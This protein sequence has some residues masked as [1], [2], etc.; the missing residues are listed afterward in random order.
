MVGNKTKKN[1]KMLFLSQKNSINRHY[2]SFSL[3]HEKWN[4]ICKRHTLPYNV[5][6]HF[7]G[8]GGGRGGGEPGDRA[9]SALTRR[10]RRKTESG[11]GSKKESVCV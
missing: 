4:Y 7:C 8:V 10:R 3:S 11:G 5:R 6:M 9:R 2:Q 1:W